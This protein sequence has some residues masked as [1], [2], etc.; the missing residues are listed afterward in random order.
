MSAGGKYTL[1]VTK[2]VEVEVSGGEAKITLNGAVIT[3]TEAGDVT[4]TS[5]TKINLSAPEIK[6]EA[7][8]GDIVIQG[9]SLVNHTHE[10]SLGGGT[11]PPK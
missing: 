3:V 6:A 8:A 2:G 11:T 4:V 10:D 9:K 7:P 1:T 5:P